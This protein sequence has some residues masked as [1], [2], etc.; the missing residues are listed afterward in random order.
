MGTA[1]PPAQ[2]VE[3][4]RPPVS[5]ILI[6]ERPEDAPTA[7]GTG[8]PAL[9]MPEDTVPTTQ[10]GQDG[11]GALRIQAFRGRQAIPLPGV[12]VKVVCPR[13]EGDVV[14]FEGVTNES[15]IIDQIVLPITAAV[16][17]NSGSELCAGYELIADAPGY[18]SIRQEVRIFP[19]IK[20]VQ[21]LQMQLVGE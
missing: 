11:R 15:G 4:V 9:E 10:D 16:G 12:H 1:L 17:S 21:P 5:N 13:P 19:G 8:T 18:A 6:P 3:E 2:I 20:T 7:E 14:F